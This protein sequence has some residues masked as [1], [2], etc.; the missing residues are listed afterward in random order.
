MHTEFW[1]GNLAERKGLEDLDTDGTKILICI[2]MELLAGRGLHL[3]G[4]G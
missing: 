1:L 3:A 4:V 2:L